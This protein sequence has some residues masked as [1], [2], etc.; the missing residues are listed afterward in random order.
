MQPTRAY[1]AEQNWY[2]WR[3]PICVMDDFGD[4]VPV[5]RDIERER[6]NHG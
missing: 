4:L 3:W 1:R 6:E 5:R 2:C